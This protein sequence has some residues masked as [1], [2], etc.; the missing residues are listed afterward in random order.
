[1]KYRIIR[2]ALFWLAGTMFSSVGPARQY[3]PVA[4]WNFEAGTGA[5]AADK[6]TRAGDSFNGNF[7]PADGVA[8]KALRFDGVTTVVIRKQAGA[9]LW[10]EEFTAEA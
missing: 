5:P 8:G 3:S 7:G 4:W 1:M 9:P 10:V 6:I 2:F